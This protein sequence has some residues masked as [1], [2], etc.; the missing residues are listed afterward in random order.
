ME[1]HYTGI[2][3]RKTPEYVL[4]QMRE[5]AARL[6]RVS[7]GMGENRCVLRSGGADG[8][9]SAFESGCDQMLGEKEIYLPWKKFNGRDIGAAYIYPPTP[10]AFRMAAKF[11][12]AWGRCS[13]GARALHARN[14]HQILGEDLETPSS[15]V[16]CWHQNTGG[17]MQA[18]R[19]AN[20]YRITVYNLAKPEAYEKIIALIKC[21]ERAHK[22]KA[23]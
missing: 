23:C 10:E 22:E 12:P 18:I 1:L 20:H 11:H 7:G 8:A 2:G 21:I 4:E 3:S 14:S 17:T 16:V 5:I 6:A 13:Y 19:I 15:F 9:D